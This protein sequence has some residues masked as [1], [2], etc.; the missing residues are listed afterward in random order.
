VIE[1]S[2]TKVRKAEVEAKLAVLRDWLHRSGRPA[3]AL[4]RPGPVAWL[5]AGITNPIDRSDPQSPVWLVVTPAETAAL[6]TAVERPRLHAEARLD[7]LGFRLEDV[8]WFEP[9]AFPRAA[10]EI[11]GAPWEAIAPD[12]EDLTA[13]RLRLLEPEGERLAALGRDTARAL[14]QAVS[15]WRPGE[16]DLDVQARLVERLERD[17]V[18]PV[19]VI[20]GGDERVERFRH[21]LAAG[22]P[23]HRVVMAVIVAMRGGLHAAAT[24]FA[25]A[26]PLPDGMAAAQLAAR[27]VEAA[28]LDAHRQ[29]ATYGDVMRACEDAYAAAGHPGAWREHYQGGVI[30]YQQREFELAPAQ[31]G[32]RWFSQP[33]EVGNAVAWNPSV[34]GGGKSEDTFLVDADGLRCVTETGDWPLT[35]AP[36]GRLRTAALE[37]AT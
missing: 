23:M 37:I 6:T 8:P 14:E 19:C 3:V 24:R 12:E 11:A 15:A 4:T 16:R 25:H 35:E 2:D 29:G 33:V 31:S 20:V 27:Q 1:D 32:S 17:G 26:G 9:D 22:E 13:L 7:E 28:M 36:G 10:A 5:T 18:L 30:G 34:A 21:P